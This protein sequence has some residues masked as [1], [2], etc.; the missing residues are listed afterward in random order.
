MDEYRIV[1]WASYDSNYPTK[2]VNENNLRHVLYAV[3]KEIM[4]NRYLFSGE[5]HQNAITGVPVFEDGTCFRAS[6]RCWAQIMASIYPDSEGNQRSY[7]DFYMFMDEE[8]IL[9]EY[10][11]LDVL[12]NPEGDDFAGIVVPTDQE[13]VYQSLSAGMPFITTDKALQVLYEYYKERLEEE[14]EKE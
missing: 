3:R 4:D 7:M 6:M 8:S 5:E 10:K 1:G 14:L 13:I 9:P 2:E 12:P 11:E